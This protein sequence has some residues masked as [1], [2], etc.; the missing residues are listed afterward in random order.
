MNSFRVVKIIRRGSKR[1]RC[2]LN[3]GLDLFLSWEDY[4]GLSVGTVISMDIS[5]NEPV[6]N[7][8]LICPLKDSKRSVKSL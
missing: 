6:F 8:P 7:G 3:N 1:C 2:L 4:P 5:Y